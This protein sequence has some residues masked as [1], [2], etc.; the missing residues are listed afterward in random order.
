MLGFLK[1]CRL[2]K[3][4]YVLR[5][6]W[7]MGLVGRSVATFVILCSGSARSPVICKIHTIIQTICTPRLG[8]MRIER[9]SSFDL[10][11]VV[12]IPLQK[13]LWEFPFKDVY[14]SF[15]KSLK[16]WNLRT[17][18]V[19]LEPRIMATAEFIQ[20]HGATPLCSICGFDPERNLENRFGIM[21]GNEP[22]EIKF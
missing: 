11:K 8:P 6:I 10:F 9:N 4:G 12:F 18:W 20:I 13:C 3:T 22:F 17:A 2:T 14:G 7:H 1:G 16:T 19:K 15:P 21:F 5:L